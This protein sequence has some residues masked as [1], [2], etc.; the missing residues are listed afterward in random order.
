[1][2]LPDVIENYIHRIGRVGRQGV[3]GVAISIIS[4]DNEEK[5]WYH[6]NCRNKGVNCFNTKLTEQGGCCIWYN[7]KSLKDQIEIRINQ[8]IPVMADDF[9]LPSGVVVGGPM[10]IK[11]QYAE[12]IKIHL[13]AIESNAQELQKLEIL[14][15]NSYWNLIMQNHPEPCN[16]DMSAITD[17]H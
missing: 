5:V 10:I 11:D 17:D 3:M 2:T 14:S 12:S 7:E 8:T 13:A 16:K 1:M 4:E 15:Q 6:S 9:K